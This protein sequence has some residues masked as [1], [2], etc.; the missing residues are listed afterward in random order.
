MIHTNLQSLALGALM[1]VAREHIGND[2]DKDDTLSSEITQ[3][4]RR[5]DNQTVFHISL[6]GK[7]E[8]GAEVTVHDKVAGT[9]RI[10]ILVLSYRRTNQESY[11]CPNALFH[12]TI[13]K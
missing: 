4:H 11:H 8:L 3:G 13:A 12:T 2:F 10:S 1:T 9:Y 5:Q 7:C 6:S